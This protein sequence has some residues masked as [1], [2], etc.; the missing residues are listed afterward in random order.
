MKYLKYRAIHIILLFLIFQAAM[1]QEPP[2]RPLR[3][4]VN[5]NL[6]FGAFYQGAAGGTVTVRTD[7]SRIAT[8]DV[9]LLTMG[10]SFSPAI[11]TL[12]GTPGRIVSFLNPGDITLPGSNGGSL[13]LNL[14]SSNPASPF[15]LTSTPLSLY[16]EGIL[17]VGPPASNPPGNFSGSFNITFMQE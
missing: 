14:G 12:T 3:I 8:G 2:P 4:T 13:K 11:Y 6:G 7:L 16:I 17:T 1:G 15:V 10:Y 9:I 5:Q